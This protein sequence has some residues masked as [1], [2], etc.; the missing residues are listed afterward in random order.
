MVA[1]TQRFS[2]A[3]GEIRRRVQAQELRPHHIIF[4]IY[5][6]RRENIN[7]FGEPRT[8]ADSIL[9]H[10]AC[11]YVDT[12]YTLFREPDL[13]VWGQVSPNHD[14]LGIPMDL[15]IGMRSRDGCLVT[16]GVSF[17]N[18]GPIH[19]NMR[20]IGEEETLCA[21]SEDGALYDHA[22]NILAEEQ[23][24]GRFDKQCR[25]FFDAIKGR[26]KPQTSFAECLP[27]MAILARLQQS[28]DA[29]R[30]SE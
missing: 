6:F 21:R 15:T 9:W 5:F 18:H 3:Y 26:R 24:A 29:K 19:Y 30:V 10:H 8:W 11:H 12:I 1:H 4:E 7:R 22:G 13:E 16:G 2:N 25:E 23:S 14:R 27:V 28:I 17:N 20:L